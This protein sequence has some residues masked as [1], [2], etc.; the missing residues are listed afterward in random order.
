MGAAVVSEWFSS[1][2]STADGARL[3]HQ[4][5]LVLGLDLPS[6]AENHL[7]TNTEILACINLLLY[8]GE[9][10]VNKSQ[11]QSRLISLDIAQ[12]TT[13][14]T[15]SKQSIIAHLRQYLISSSL[16]NFCGSQH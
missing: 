3:A 6:T 7:G 12:S 13:D 14:T 5:E 1:G 2:N 4:S 9:T 8:P 15:K 10:Q 16:Q 11:V